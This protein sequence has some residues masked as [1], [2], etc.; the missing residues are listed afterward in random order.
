MKPPPAVFQNSGP[1]GTGGW[2]FRSRTTVLFMITKYWVIL[3]PC[4]E[5]KKLQ[6]KLD[7]WREQSPRMPFSWER[8]NLPRPVVCE[9]QVTLHL[10]KLQESNSASKRK[11]KTRWNHVNGEEAP[12]CPVFPTWLDHEQSHFKASS[13]GTGQGADSSSVLP[14]YLS[15]CSSRDSLEKWG[16]GLSMDVEAQSTLPIAKRQR[17]NIRNQKHGRDH[18]ITS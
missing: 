14:S 8:I 2:S 6:F 17:V 1:E 13:P 10:E 4:K 9:L 18:S 3:T 15:R 5:A 16:T 11:Y 12:A 7:S